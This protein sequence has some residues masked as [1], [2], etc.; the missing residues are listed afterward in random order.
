TKR[1][2][3][4]LMSMIVSIV[5]DYDDE[6]MM[7]L[8]ILIYVPSKHFRYKS[9]N[10]FEMKKKYLK[11][12]ANICLIEIGWFVFLLSTLRL[13]CCCFHKKFQND[14]MGKDPNLFEFESDWP[15]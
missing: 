6:G 1:T 10:H 9:A 4:D 12:N 13:T 14:L 11:K 5:D 3:R 2:N 7:T 8:I 15:N